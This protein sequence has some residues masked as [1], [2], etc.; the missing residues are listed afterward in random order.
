MRFKK[1][2]IDGGERED[3]L[4]LVKKKACKKGVNKRKF[5]ENA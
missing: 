5:K 4:Q 3:I 1:M 2:K